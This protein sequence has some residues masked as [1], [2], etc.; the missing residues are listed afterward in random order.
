MHAGGDAVLLAQAARQT[1][2]C[3][4]RQTLDRNEVVRYSRRLYG[5]PMGAQP[6]VHSARQ[7]WKTGRPFPGPSF[8]RFIRAAARVGALARCAP[9]PQLSDVPPVGVQRAG[10]IVAGGDGKGA[11][12]DTKVWHGAAE[13][14]P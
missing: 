5:R 2:D 1:P 11:N 8:Q 14:G 10:G 4:G 9:S 6:P 12:R 3:G 7:P 13:K